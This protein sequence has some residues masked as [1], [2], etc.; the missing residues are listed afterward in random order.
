MSRQ[1]LEASQ[2]RRDHQ[3]SILRILCSGISILD[4]AID[5]FMT[6]GSDPRIDVALSPPASETVEIEPISSLTALVRDELQTAREACD[7]LQSRLF[8]YGDWFEVSHLELN[9]LAELRRRI[10]GDYVIV[11]G[12]RGQLASLSDHILD[13]REAWEE[14]EI[15]DGSDDS[16]C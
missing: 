13:L 8:A 4:R 15:L 10:E 6:L 1:E 14:C 12:I 11:T 3:R 16:L 7:T 9:C 2:R 5:H